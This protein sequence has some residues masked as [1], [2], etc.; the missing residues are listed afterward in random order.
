MFD[1]V[2]V[3]Y[4]MFGDLIFYVTGSQDENELILYTVLQAFY[5]SI[6]LLLRYACAV[7]CACHVSIVN[8]HILRARWSTRQEFWPTI[9]VKVQVRW[10]IPLKL[11][12]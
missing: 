9:Y 7:A 5:E 10:C 4:K 8:L 12:N 11:Y 6:S 1:D 2:I 3:V